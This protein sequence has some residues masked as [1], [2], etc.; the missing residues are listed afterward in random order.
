MLFLSGNIIISEVL[1]NEEDN[2][3]G[4]TQVER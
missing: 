1:R 3:F 4:N 2:Y